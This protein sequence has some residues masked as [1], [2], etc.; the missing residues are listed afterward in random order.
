[1]P[2][3]KDTA[4]FFSYYDVTEKIAPVIGILSFGYIEELTGS[5]EKLSA[6]LDYLFYYRS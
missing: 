2:E 4:S 3:T 1:M 5:H 6:V